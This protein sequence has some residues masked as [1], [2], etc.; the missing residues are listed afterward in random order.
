MWTET[1][2]GFE[3]TI[4]NKLIFFGKKGCTL[5]D[6]KMHFKEIEFRT[7][8]QTHSDISIF[9]SA[10][11][12]IIQ[13]DAHF[14]QEMNVGLVIKTADCIPLL[15]EIPTKKTILAI[16]A[17]WRGVENQI[18]VKALGRLRLDA[19]DVITAYIG[20]HILKESFEVQSDVKDLLLQSAF[21][22]KQNFVSLRGNKYTID[23]QNII[24]TQIESIISSASIHLTNMDTYQNLLFN[25]YRTDQ[26]K[27]RNISFIAQKMAAV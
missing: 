16:H 15:I 4:E 23:L 7:V 13:A 1:Q 9:S 17:G 24:K 20:P 2:L 10:G 12:E 14:T 11:S 19:N 21:G 6:L 25:S 26:T 3:K 5:A 18:T 27:L 22:E 8:H